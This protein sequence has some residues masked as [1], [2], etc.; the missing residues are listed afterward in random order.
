[1]Q[2]N[3]K[4]SMRNTKNFIMMRFN[5]CGFLLFS[6]IKI[7]L[8]VSSN[9]AEKKTEARRGF[10]YFC[11]TLLCDEYGEADENSA[12]I[13][14]TIVI[15]RTGRSHQFWKNI[16]KCIVLF[17]HYERPS[18]SHL[19]VKVFLNMESTSCVLFLTELLWAII[20]CEYRL[21]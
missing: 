1:M 14:W 8:N 2:S 19:S 15:W 18:G 13:T 5:L 11:I 20:L 16:K 6:F 4:M 17:Y 9:S 7:R 3:L 12:R 21:Q 10:D